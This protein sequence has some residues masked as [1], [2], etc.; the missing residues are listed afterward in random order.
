MIIANGAI[1]AKIKSG[2]GIDASTGFPTQTTYTWGDP[3]DCQFYPNAYNAVGEINGEDFKTAQ[4]F[5]LI[6]EQPFAATQ[7]RLKDLAGNLVG[8]FAVISSQ[9]LQ[10]VGQVKILL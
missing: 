2:G 7:V 8:E 1:E 5:V 4:Y 6:E 9:L 3:I 10:A